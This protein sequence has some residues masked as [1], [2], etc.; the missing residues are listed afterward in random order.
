MPYSKEDRST[1]PMEVNRGFAA[2]LMGKIREKYEDRIRIDIYD[3]RC[4]LWIFDLIRFNVRATEV[5]WVMDGKLLARGIP[6]W[7]ELNGRI[8]ELTK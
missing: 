1:S 7:E 4:P 8:E 5:V 6:S 2:D 3:P